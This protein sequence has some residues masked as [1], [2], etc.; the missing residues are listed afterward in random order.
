MV[1]KRMH[2]IDASGIRKVFDL[3]AKLKNPINLSIGQPDFDVPDGAKEAAIQAIRDGK[4]RYTQT[5]GIAELRQRIAAMLTDQF[6]VKEPA[7]LVTS[8]TSGGLLLALLAAVDE[9]DEV[10]IGDPYF[11]M[12]KHLARLIGARPVFVDTYPGFRLTAERVRPLIG[13]RTRVLILNSPCNPSGAVLA[14]AEIDALLDLARRHRLL[15]ITDEIYSAFC[16]DGPFASAYGRYDNT[17]LLNGFSKTYAMTGWRLGYAAGPPELIQAMTMLQ[18]YS[19][20]C[21]PSMVQWGGVAALDIDMGAQIEEFRRR[22]DFIYGALQDDFEVTRPG[23]AFYIFPQA[24]GGGAQEFV[25]EAIRRNVLIIP[26]GVFSERDTHFR[27]TYSADMETLKR[28][29][30]VL[31]RLAREMA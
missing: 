9:G 11:V 21:A 20:V 22:R 15:V 16:Y 17:L 27:V 10:L 7:L 12:Y 13:D 1:A 23:G 31:T 14:R 25:A 28:G 2:L 6:G 5:Q 18:Q 24:P 29:A 30:E 8:G 3:A 4:N 19:F 26:G